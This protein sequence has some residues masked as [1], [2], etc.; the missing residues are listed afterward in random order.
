MTPGRLPLSL[1]RG[2]TYRWRFRLWD[3]VAQTEASDL[4][5]VTATAQIR[6]RVGGNLITALDC[7]VVLP[8]IVEAVLTAANSALLPSTGAWDLQLLYV[9]G[10]V[11]TVLAGP[12]SVVADVTQR[13]AAPAPISNR[14]R[15]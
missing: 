14:P 13:S 15:R 12:V 7:T 9:S 11:A 3:D 1:Y 8:N 6:D 5:G 4:T 10:D 2:D